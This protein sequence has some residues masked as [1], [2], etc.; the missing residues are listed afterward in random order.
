[1]IIWSL[2]S[3]SFKRPGRFLGDSSVAA[4]NFSKRRVAFQATPTS[5][6]SFSFIFS[7]FGSFLK[8]QLR[9]GQLQSRSTW[10]LTFL[11]FLALFLPG[12]RV[13]HGWLAQW[14]PSTSSCSCWAASWETLQEGRRRWDS[15]ILWCQTGWGH[16]WRGLQNPECQGE[17]GHRARASIRNVWTR[18]T[19]LGER[20]QG[21]RLR[22]HHGSVCRSS[23]GSSCKFPGDFRL[24][25][26]ARILLYSFAAV[27]EIFQ[28]LPIF[29]EFLWLNSCSLDFQTIFPTWFSFFLVGDR[30]A[31][32][33]S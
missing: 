29:P 11:S 15:R 7:S 28:S 3:D 4:C 25:S 1:M 14:A 20:Q 18:V 23:R 22:S 8:L 26:Q 30:T 6:C 33:R 5:D 9:P 31:S 2:L 21:L 10:S 24:A 27:L 19:R 17:T 32:C 12:N 16:S 13:S